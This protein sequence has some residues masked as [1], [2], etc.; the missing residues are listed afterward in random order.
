RSCLGCNG[1]DGSRAF[2][3]ELNLVL[4]DFHHIAM[5]QLGFADALIVHVGPIQRSQ[6]FDFI[7]VFVP[8]NTGVMSG[9][10]KIVDLQIV[11]RQTPDA[12]GRLAERDLLEH[13]AFKFQIEFCHCGPP[14]TNLRSRFLYQGRSTILSRR[15]VML[16]S[17]PRSL[18]ACTSWLHAFSRPG[19]LLITARISSSRT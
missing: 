11:I 18:A 9:N 7:M 6:V 8:G 5:A 14:G 4:T 3:L 15:Q 1:S 19:E 13:G 12:S 16:S 17:P 10:S 2:I